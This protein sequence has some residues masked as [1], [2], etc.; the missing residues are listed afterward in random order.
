MRNNTRSMVPA[1]S[2]PACLCLPCQLLTAL[3]SLSLFTCCCM[4]AGTVVKVDTKGE[5]DKPFKLHYEDGDKE[6]VTLQE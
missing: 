2:P 5:D 4:A 6:W 3:L 1:S